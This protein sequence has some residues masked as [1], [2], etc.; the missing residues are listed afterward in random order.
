[1]TCDVFYEYK[2]YY[3]I[4]GINAKILKFMSIFLIF[5]QNINTKKTE[6]QNYRIKEKN[7]IEKH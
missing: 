2:N 5:C 7:K 4:F 6:K 3:D 1:M